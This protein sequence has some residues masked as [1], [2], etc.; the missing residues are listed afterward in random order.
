M[1]A[2]V[3]LLGGRDRFW[4]GFGVQTFGWGFVDAAIA[5]LGGRAS[6]RK[7][8]RPEANTSEALARESRLLRRF[9]R[10]N[11]G[12]DVFYILGGLNLTR[13]ESARWRGQGWGVVVQG[14]F[15]LLFDLVQSRRVPLAGAA[16]MDADS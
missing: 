6:R 11:A 9:L 5:I 7:A 12:L 3:F 15:L 16:D 13:Q 1:A 8:R 14:L 4:Q 2:G 10:I